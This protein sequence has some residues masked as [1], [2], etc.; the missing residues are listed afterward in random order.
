VPLGLAYGNP[1]LLQSVGLGPLLQGLGDERQYRNDEQIDDS[2]RSV[3]FEIPKPGARDPS[4]C[5]TPVVTPGCFSVVQD[6]GAIDVE[7]G[8]DHGMPYYNQMRIAYG[9]KPKRSYASITGESTSRFPRRILLGVRRRP[10]DDPASL[11]FTRLL[12]DDGHAIRPHTEEA[13]EDVVSA[14]R[15][16]S[17]A[18]RLKAIYGPRNVNRVD[19]FVGMTAEPHVPGTEFGELQLAMWERQFEAL[20]DGDRFFYLNDP[21]LDRIRDRYGIDYRQSLAHVIELNTN[22]KVRPNVF[23]APIG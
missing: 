9:L 7:R 10:V 22:A 20:R 5:E 23:F 11:Q 13:A 1:G 2:M 3:L 17:L 16:T 12:D 6:L 18:S 19:A 4:K 14:T 15:R 21:A 8:R